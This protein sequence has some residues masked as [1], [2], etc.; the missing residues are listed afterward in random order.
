MLSLP[1]PTKRKSDDMFQP[2]Q[3]DPKILARA[4]YL[5]KNLSQGIDGIEGSEQPVS[6]D[7]VVN[8]PKYQR[9]FAFVAQI[10][11]Q[12][13]DSQMNT[14]PDTS[15]LLSA[16]EAEGRT[17]NNPNIR[18]SAIA[19]VINQAC[20]L[21]PAITAKHL[22]NW[23]V[24][25]GYLCNVKDQ[26]NKTT[27]DV[28]ESGIALGIT[29]DLEMKANEGTSFISIRYTP[30]AQQAFIQHLPEILQYYSENP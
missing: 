23:Q 19:K 16:M 8:N 13:S 2:N 20:R 30:Q 5:M 14:N 18:I 17:T 10:L 22:N 15:N 7:S 3:V 6:A 9:C 25:K 1:N 28:T 27:R 29:R 12:I 24:S 4:T 21:S 11:E 26:E